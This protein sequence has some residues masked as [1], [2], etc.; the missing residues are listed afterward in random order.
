MALAW[1]KFDDVKELITPG[2][3]PDNL[4]QLILYAI[5]ENRVNFVREFLNARWKVH[6]FIK[7]DTLKSLYSKV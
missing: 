3:E 2:D 5:K 1:D 6:D 7:Y 4:E